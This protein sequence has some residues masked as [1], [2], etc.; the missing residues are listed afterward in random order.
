MKCSRG[1]LSGRIKL[2]FNKVFLICIL[3]SKKTWSDL[4]ICFTSDFH[5]FHSIKCLN[6]NCS[7]FQI[8]SGNV[9]FHNISNYLFWKEWRRFNRKQTD[10]NYVSFGY[11]FFF[12]K[13]I[14]S[15]LFL[16]CSVSKNAFFTSLSV[17]FYEHCSFKSFICFAKSFNGCRIQK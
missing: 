14:N 5:W 11:C 12:G 6:R 8:E 4:T 3:Q 1:Q 17:V 16:S 2:K 13:Q 10:L 7:R 9:T 15:I